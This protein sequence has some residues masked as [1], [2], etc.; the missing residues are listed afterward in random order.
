MTAAAVIPRQ[1]PGRRVRAGARYGDRCLHR[2]A[3]SGAAACE[4]SATA[5]RGAWLTSLGV[6]VHTVWCGTCWRAR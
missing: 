6:L 3:P 4:T 5:R 2:I 1:R